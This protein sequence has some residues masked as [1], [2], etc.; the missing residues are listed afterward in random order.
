MSF[1]LARA[2]VAVVLL[3]VFSRGKTLPPEPSGHTKNL[4]LLANL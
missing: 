4:S 1:S 3:L 2:P